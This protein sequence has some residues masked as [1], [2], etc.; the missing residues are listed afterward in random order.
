MPVENPIDKIE[1]EANLKRSRED[2]SKLARHGMRWT[3]QEVVLLRDCAL[4]DSDV[5]IQVLVKKF[6]RTPDAINSKMHQI[7]SNTLKT[8]S[9]ADVSVKLKRSES[10]LQDI[11][12]KKR[13]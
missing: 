7:L 8:S 10:E 9:L 11:L 6:Q 4:E 5:R 3:P 1:D 13:D 12:D 2:D